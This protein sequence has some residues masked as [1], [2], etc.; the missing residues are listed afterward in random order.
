MIG[1][2]AGL[3]IGALGIGA[4]NEYRQDEVARI[5]MQTIFK[6]AD[7]YLLPRLN[8]LASKTPL[9]RKNLYQTAQTLGAY[10][11]DP[12]KITDI[13]RRIGDISGGDPYKMQSV[14][15]AYGRVQSMGFLQGQ[16][17]KYDT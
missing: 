6:G 10:G 17:K 7:E 1:L 5:K 13:T 16:E 2:G 3:G 11:I 12:T 15:T 4:I 8:R 14:A 9:T